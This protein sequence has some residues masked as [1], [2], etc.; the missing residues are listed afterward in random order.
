M[1]A[2][3]LTIIVTGPGRMSVVSLIKKIPKALQ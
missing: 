1:L 3:V 2:G